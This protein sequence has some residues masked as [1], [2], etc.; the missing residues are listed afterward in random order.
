MGERTARDDSWIGPKDKRNMIKM[1]ISERGMQIIWHIL[2]SDFGPFTKNL[3]SER[4]KKGERESRVR[5]M[6]IGIS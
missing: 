1:T 2:V 3:F 4:K 6:Q 5:A